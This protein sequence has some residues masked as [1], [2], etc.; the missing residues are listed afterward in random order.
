M[1]SLRKSI[2]AA[3]CPGRVALGQIAASHGLFE[4]GAGV[5]RIMATPKSA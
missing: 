2:R 1:V 4:S 3:I 5:I